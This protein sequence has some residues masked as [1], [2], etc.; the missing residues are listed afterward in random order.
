MTL[1]RKHRRSP[2]N[3]A[4]KGGA[5]ASAVPA[6]HIKDDHIIL[7]G[8]CLE[9]MTELRD[10]RGFREQVDLVYLDPPFN[11]KAEYAFLFG[12]EK[13]AQRALTAFKDTWKWTDETET[14]YEDYIASGRGGRFLESMRSTLGTTGNGGAMLS[15]LAMMTPRLELMRD[16]MKPTGGVYLHCDQTASHYLKLA[17][18]AVF[19]ADNFRNDIVWCYRKMPAKSARFQRNHDNI[20][21]YA[22]SGAA[23]FNTQ[24]GEYSESS[25]RTYERARK[26]GYNANLKKR[27]VTVFDWKLYRRAVAR[28]D[29]PSDMQPQEFKGEGPPLPD[30]WEIPILS[31]NSP[32][33]MGFPTQKPLPLLE[34]IVA[35]S[36]DRGDIVLDPFCGCGTTL[37]A[38]RKLGRKFIGVDL[39]P[40]AA[41][42]VKARMGNAPYNMTVRVGHMQPQSADDF[43]DLARRGRYLDFQYHAITRIRGAIPNRTQSGDRGVDGWVLVRREGEKRDEM[44]VISVKAGTQL[45][46]TMVRDLRGVVADFRPRPLAGILITLAEPTRG[47]LETAAAAGDYEDGDRRR[48]RIQIL[49]IRRLLAEKWNL[50]RRV[51]AEGVEE[52]RNLFPAL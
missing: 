21:F 26:I 43:A 6:P 14:A 47:M 4:P 33:R 12:R 11:S 41:R 9:V 29:L 37:A 45:A 32:E 31:P 46:P 22:K 42:T 38:C 10:E 50:P 35:A 52:F 39:E 30:W 3:P 48:P 15:Y 49:P 23:R 24:R 27:M 2:N 19:G 5:V 20:L 25:L 40:I 36:S 51:E 18:D 28:G 13:A 17:M 34:R 44:V 16:L 8:D 7:L 1:P